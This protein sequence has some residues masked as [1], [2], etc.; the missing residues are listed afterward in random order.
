MGVGGA[1]ELRTQHEDENLHGEARALRRG[2]GG[3]A[4]SKS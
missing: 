1:L 4:G 2:V 3:R